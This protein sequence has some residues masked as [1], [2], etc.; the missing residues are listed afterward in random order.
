LYALN[1]DK[2]RIFAATKEGKKM[3]PGTSIK[4]KMNLFK[5]DKADT[6]IM[7]VSDL[8]KPDEVVKTLEPL[9]VHKLFGPD[10][11]SMILFA[12]EVAT[13]NAAPWDKVE[14]LQ[15]NTWF[16]TKANKDNN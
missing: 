12:D 14:D 10:Y 15:G 16:V 5:S 9:P 6:I 8:S 1:R 13:G 11:T 4:W 2:R 3:K 7:E